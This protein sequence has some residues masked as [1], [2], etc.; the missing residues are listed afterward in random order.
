MIDNS[1]ASTVAANKSAMKNPNPLHDGED[2]SQDDTRALLHALQSELR[3]GGAVGPSGIHMMSHKF[4]R[5]RRASTVNDADQDQDQDQNGDHPKEDPNKQPS[6]LVDFIFPPR[7]KGMLTRAV[8]AGTG[9]AYNGKKQEGS[10]PTRQGR[11]QPHPRSSSSLVPSSSPFMASLST[12]LGEEVADVSANE[13]ASSQQARST[14]S[15]K[16]DHDENLVAAREYAATMRRLSTLNTD[17][18]KP[19]RKP[20]RSNT[21]SSDSSTQRSRSSSFG[22]LAHTFV[23]AIEAA[24]N[25]LSEEATGSTDHSTEFITSE[26]SAASSAHREEHI[27]HT[28]LRDLRNSRDGDSLT[29]N[30]V[31]SPNTRRSRSPSTVAARGA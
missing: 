14:E 30:N 7:A 20:R 10:R 11:N 25:D 13:S 8:S 15:I 27:V 4:L 5:E 17:D 31:G 24:L 29:N 3:A 6:A 2:Y 16:K 28:E 23:D 18:I 21:S 9:G 19:R 12:L 22:N 1:S 26:H